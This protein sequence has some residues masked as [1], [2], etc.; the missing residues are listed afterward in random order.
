MALVIAIIALILITLVFHFLSPWWFTPIA[1]NWGTVDTTIDITFWVTGIVFVLVNAFIAYS[2]YRFRYQKDKKADYQPENKKLESWLTLITTLGVAAM[3]APGLFVWAKFVDS[4]DD[5]KQLEVL[6]QQWHWSYRF[7]GE[8]GV[9]GKVDAQFISEQNPFGIHPKDQHGQDDRLVFSNELHLPIDQPTKVLLRSLDVLHDYAVPQF[10][11]KMDLVPGMVTYFWFTP[12]EKGI[13]EVLC[14]ELCGIAHHTMRGSVVVEGEAEFQQWLTSHPTFREY[15][16]KV[17]ADIDKGKALYQVCGACHGANGEGNAALNAPKLSGLGRDYLKRQLNY[18]KQGVRGSDE[19]DAFGQQMK[20]MAAV[21]AD[22]TSMEHLIAYMDTFPKL[23]AD[24]TLKQGDEKRGRKLY[25][26]CAN[27]HGKNGEGIYATG[28]PPLMG[29]HDWYIKRQLEHFK[30]GVRGAHQKDKYGTQMILMAKV[31]KD[32]NAID[33][34]TAYINTFS[35]NDI[36]KNN[37]RDS[38]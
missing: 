35:H 19:Q 23:N 2:I 1:S 18:F 27:C 7:P 8:D 20:P 21:I 16:T 5:A 11:V 38:E 6:G 33:D 36:K 12:T 29:Q 9:L 13:Y 30:Q 17:T 15:Q 34:V 24:S 37:E 14:E 28:A 32:E 4:P 22:D 3:L 10:R 31:L 26:T 25:R